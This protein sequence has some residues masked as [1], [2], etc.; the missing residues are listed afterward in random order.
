MTLT[1]RKIMETWNQHPLWLSLQSQE[2]QIF[3][4]VK[5]KLFFVF[6]LSEEKNNGWSLVFQ[7]KLLAKDS[8]ILGK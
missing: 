4:K 7:W 8:Q 6:G 5:G 3:L 2:E 1:Q